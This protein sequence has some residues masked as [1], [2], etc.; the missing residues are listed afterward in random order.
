MKGL[1]FLFVQLIFSCFYSS[2]R[3]TSNSADHGV[4]E[5]SG[6]TLLPMSS[7]VPRAKDTDSGRAFRSILNE[8]DTIYLDYTHSDLEFTYRERQYFF[9]LEPAT[10]NFYVFNVVN[11]KTVLGRFLILNP[12]E[13][14]LELSLECG[15][16]IPKPICNL[17][18]IFYKY[19]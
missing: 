4:E 19:Y 1:S 5:K 15:H 17:N 9:D 6:T 12:Q 18:L 13:D 11:S 8:A 3:N 14:K 16:G 7:Y 10:S 2:C